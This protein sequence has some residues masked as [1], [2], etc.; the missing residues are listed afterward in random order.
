MKTRFVGFRISEDAYKKIFK[1]KHEKTITQFFCELI[2]REFDKKEKSTED[3]TATLQKMEIL[4]Q[5]IENTYEHSPQDQEYIKRLEK[6][7]SLLEMNLEISV[8][9]AASS[10]ASTNL[11]RRKYPTLIEDT[12]EKR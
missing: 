5:K 8:A 6:I 12:L 2:D 4:M 11:I 3:C 10:P 7:F 9:I 1:L